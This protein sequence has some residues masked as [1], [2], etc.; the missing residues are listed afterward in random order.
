MIQTAVVGASGYAGAELVA[1]LADHP[2]VRLRAVQADSTAGLDFAAVHPALRHR[3]RGPLAPF[4][5]EALA[6]LD[7]VFLALPHGVS[8]E[9]VQAL[10]GRVGKLFDLSGDLR[11]ADAQEYR[12]WYGAEHPAPDL[13]GRAAYGLPELFGDQV[14]SAQIIACAGCY[15]TAVQLAAAPALAAAAPAA[16]PSPLQVTAA[17]LSGTSG[18]G[19]KADLALSYSQVGGNLR[20]YRIGRHQHAPEMA[21]G[22]QRITGRPVQVTFVPHLV[23]IVRGIL[24]TVVIPPPTGVAADTDPVELYRQ[25][26]AGA[27]FVRVADPAERPPEVADVVRTNFCDLAPAIDQASGQLVVVAAI[28]N[29]LKGAAGQAVQLFNL[30]FHLPETTGLPGPDP[31]PTQQPDATGALHV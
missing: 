25:F 30:A 15:A 10:A 28:D 8:G 11:L 22:L 31:R 26:Y 3:Y 18:A 12:R 29:L 6:G 27:P 14:A 7:A 4:D 21:M 5:P 20:A 9:A 19:R 2:R 1:L 13:L 23:P 24:A 16:A 17:G